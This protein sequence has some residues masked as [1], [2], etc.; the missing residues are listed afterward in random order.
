MHI[1]RCSTLCCIQHKD[2]TIVVALYSGVRQGCSLSP[3]LWSIFVCYALHLL[4]ARV[5]LAALSAFS[6]DLLAQWTIDAPDETLLLLFLTWP[7]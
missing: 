2:H 6:D 3:A 7:L 5:P 1:H 4:S